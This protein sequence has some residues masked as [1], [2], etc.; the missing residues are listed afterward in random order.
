MSGVV[1]VLELY[2]GCVIISFKINTLESIL[3]GQ[4]RTLFEANFRGTTR[5]VKQ[6]KRPLEP[7]KTPWQARILG[8]L[9]IEIYSQIN[10][11]N[12]V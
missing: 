6:K 7:L 4:I 8:V 9:A 11:L 10:N 5:L 2:R 12:V 1:L 3:P